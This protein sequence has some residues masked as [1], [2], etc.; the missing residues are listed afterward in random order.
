[1]TQP[2]S[3]L[4]RLQRAFTEHLRNPEQVPVPEGLDPRR[5]GIYSEL[6]FGNLSSLL[7]EF[8]P[9]INSILE[10]SAWDNLV[11]EFLIRHQSQTPYF[12]QIAEEF[13]SYL[14]QGQVSSD[15]PDFLAELAHYEWIELALF[16]AEQELPANNLSLSQ[17]KEEPV[18]LSPLAVPLIYA[19]PVHQISPDFLPEA[20]S[21]LP[22]C[23]LAFRD[24]DD[25]VRFFELQPLAYKL[26][27]SMSEN[28]G[29]I[30]QDWLTTQATETGNED[31]SAFVEGGVA[32]LEQLNQFGLVTQ[33]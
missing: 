28:P 15:T 6:V 12:P 19:Y 14:D 23:L 3:E 10:S 22:V 2:E 9:V 11:R 32:L 24:R 7:S 26:L 29:L 31:V 20:P 18:S 25:S 33:A 1:V 4:R 13:V 5:M 21:E 16:T 8:F 27:E 17:L 30:V